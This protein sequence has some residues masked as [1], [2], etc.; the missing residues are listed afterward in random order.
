MAEDFENDGVVFDV[1]DERFGHGYGYVLG[2][3]EVGGS[4]RGGGGGGG[5]S[6]WFR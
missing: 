3:G 6:N 1:I 4:G 5:V 2:V